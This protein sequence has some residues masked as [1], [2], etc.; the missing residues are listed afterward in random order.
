MSVSRRLAL[1]ALVAVSALGLSACGDGGSGAADGQAGAAGDA[2]ITVVTATNVYGDIA[3]AVGG[4]DV[5]V[6]LAVLGELL[7]IPGVGDCGDDVG[8]HEPEGYG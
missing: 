8:G 7:L 2:A 5:G 6:A 1:P 3:A 4:D